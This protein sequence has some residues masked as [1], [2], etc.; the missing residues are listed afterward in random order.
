MSSKREFA[1]IIAMLVAAYPRFA[2]PRESVAV[3]EEFLKDIPTEELVIAARECV[4]RYDFFPSVHEI[5]KTVTDLR[6]AARKIPSAYEAWE[7]L[8]KAGNGIMHMTGVNPDGKFWIEKRE[9]EFK[10]PLIGEVAVMLGWPKD[11]PGGDK[12]Y[13]RTTFIKAYN[14]RLQMY[15]GYEMMT[16][17][18][19]EAICDGEVKALAS[20][21]KR[22][23]ETHQIKEQITLEIENGKIIRS[24]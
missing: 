19:K 10:H 14:E 3:Y 7:D 11:F 13:D 23:G 24:A 1:K 5:R 16:P 18:T 17:E 2:L 15:V 22:D 20:V 9:Y 21:S 6:C 4:T 12:S 8:C